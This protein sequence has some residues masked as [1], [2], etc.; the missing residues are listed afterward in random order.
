MF[1]G[2]PV[3]VCRDKDGRAGVEYPVSQGLGREAAEDDRVDGADPCARE[4][5][6]RQ[7][8]DHGQI[9]GDPVA[10][11]HA[12]LLEDIGEPGDLLKQLL[13]SDTF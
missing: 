7:L 12:L 2:T 6:D 3:A 5:G 10:F 4:H 13:V 8:R 1:A 11:L 9:N